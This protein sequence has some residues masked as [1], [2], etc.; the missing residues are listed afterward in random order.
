MALGRWA[1]S[2][3]A[4][5]EKPVRVLDLGYHLD[6]TRA[7]SQGFIAGLRE[8][9]PAAEIVLS[10]NTQS[11]RQSA[12]Q[13]T[14]DVLDVHGE[15]NMIFAI[16]DATAWGAWQACEERGIPPGAMTL[17]TFGLEGDTL[18]RCAG[19]RE[20]LQRRPG[21]VPRDRGTGVR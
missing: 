6:N 16:N 12:Y 3:A 13:L 14:S 5:R 11:T 2:H 1:G 21:D 4:Q 15:I 7:R 19:E 18:P 9:L 17:L 20:L 8:T 10:I